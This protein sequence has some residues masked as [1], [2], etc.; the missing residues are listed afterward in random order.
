MYENGLPNQAL[1]DHHVGM[2]RE[3]EIH[4]CAAVVV[5]EA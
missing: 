4:S 1:L 5:C 3:L 2:A